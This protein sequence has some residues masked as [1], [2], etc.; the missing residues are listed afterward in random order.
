MTLSSTNHSP[1]PF[2]SGTVRIL[3]NSATL[4]VHR[5]FVETRP[6]LF[7]R[8]KFPEYGESYDPDVASAD[9]KTVSLD[10]GHILVLQLYAGAYQL[11]PQEAAPTTQEALTIAFK[12]HSLA[13]EYELPELEA[14]ARDQITSLGVQTSVLT[15]LNV[16]ADAY[17]QTGAPTSL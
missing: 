14:L 3:V 16:V 4:R 9:L 13:R 6:K 11:R 5:A 2:T 17:P 10:V 15:V 12:V 1:S 7:K 8:F